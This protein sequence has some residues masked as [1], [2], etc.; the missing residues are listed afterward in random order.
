[1]KNFRIIIMS[2]VVLLGAIFLVSCGEDP[3]EITL[4][5]LNVE[6]ETTK[7]TIVL[8]KVPSSALGVFKNIVVKVNN[9]ELAMTNNTL[10]VTDLTP[11]TLYHIVISY[12]YVE[13]EQTKSGVNELDATTKD[14]VAPSATL[15]A[16]LVDTNIAK[17]SYHIVDEEQVVTDYQ[18]VVKYQ[19]KEDTYELKKLTGE[20]TLEDLTYEMLYKVELLVNYQYGL[21]I[22]S[23]TEEAEFETLEKP[24]LS[25][26]IDETIPRNLVKSIPALA[27]SDESIIRS[28]PVHN[29][30]HY[31]YNDDELVGKYIYRIGFYV[32]QVNNSN[33][34]AKS[35]IFSIVITE[36][37]TSE[38][39]HPR[40]NKIIKVEV[41]DVG[42]IEK[43]IDIALGSGKVIAF[44]LPT[45]TAVVGVVYGQC[46][47]K[48]SE[49]ASYNANNDNSGIM[50]AFN[51][52]TKEEPTVKPID[53]NNIF[54]GK[55]LAVIGD[56][57]SAF[58]GAIPSENLA[59]W[60]Y[61]PNATSL[62][63]R[64]VNDMW[65]AQL[66]NKTGMTRGICNAWAGTAVASPCWQAND[67]CSDLYR[68]MS[69]KTSPKDNPDVIICLIGTNDVAG[70][71]TKERFATSYEKMINNIQAYYPDAD[72]FVCTIINEK[73]TKQADRAIVNGEIKRLA[74]KY[75]LGLIDLASCGISASDPTAYLADSV[76]PNVS[77]MNLMAEK[78]YK[79]VKKYY[80]VE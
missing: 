19:T 45:D 70:A 32:K 49:Y 72:L 17:I 57:I 35:G 1:M 9:Q 51:I 23:I 59:C 53:P 62:G 18:V 46:G 40:V 69:L 58:E 4:Q 30:S 71:V 55:T 43:N 24:D 77:G 66:A 65:W 79:D 50:L 44:G 47:N 5:K 75:E 41:T 56:S 2:F 60:C 38:N 63:V 67:I 21:A 54:V 7:S 64:N 28:L 37:P 22:K 48:E 31:Y 29:A 6:C 68:I 27:L 42:Y 78:A 74:T 25:D 3:V 20:I 61:G 16:E 52:W 73:L 10:T 8:T 11:A 14:V 80:G 33:P 26:P 15:E 39:M 12:D 36:E 76:H 34:D 13:S